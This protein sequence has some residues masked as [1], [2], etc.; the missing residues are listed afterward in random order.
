MS[1]LSPGELA[2]VPS[3]WVWVGQK[4]GFIEILSFFD[5]KWF[6]QMSKFWLNQ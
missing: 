2:I 3:L 6:F 4:N 5:N 1:V